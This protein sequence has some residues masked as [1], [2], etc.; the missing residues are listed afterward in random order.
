MLSRIRELR[1]TP[2][3]PEAPAIP[4]FDLE[5]VREAVVRDQALKEPQRQTVLTALA[6][7][8]FVAELKSGA[9]GAALMF[10]ISRYLKMKPSNQ[11]LLSIAGFGIGKIIYDHRTAPGKWSTYNTKTKMYEIN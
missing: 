6:D 8:S 4:D 7:P 10:L 3:A 9:V 1:Q 5:S 11:L 2:A